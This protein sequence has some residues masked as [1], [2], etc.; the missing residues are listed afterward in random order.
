[1]CV[2]MTL[3]NC[4]VPSSW[5]T[6]KNRSY[7]CAYDCVQ[8]CYTV[9]KALNNSDLI[10]PLILLTIITALRSDDVYRREGVFID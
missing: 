2:L 8:L 4:A 10:F 9:N 6:C 5:Y 7:V 1:M 3:C